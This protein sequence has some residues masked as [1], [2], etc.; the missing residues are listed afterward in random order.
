MCLES[1][2]TRPSLETYPECPDIIRL[3]FVS[4]RLPHQAREPG[5]AVDGEEP[6][7]WARH[8]VVRLPGETVGSQRRLLHEYTQ[9]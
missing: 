7:A 9:V 3:E 5:E 4:A 2:E 6:S 1:I 8:Q